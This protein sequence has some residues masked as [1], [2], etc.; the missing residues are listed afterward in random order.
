MKISVTEMHSFV[1]VIQ[2]LLIL[3]SKS[4]ILNS[5]MSIS[6]RDA[7]HLLFGKSNLEI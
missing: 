6:R 2:M 1:A 3:L 7:E 4:G 5:S